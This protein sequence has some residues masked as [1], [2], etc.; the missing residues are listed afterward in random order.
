VAARGQGRAASFKPAEL[1][2]MKLLQT[3][4]AAST[5]PGFHN[6]AATIACSRMTR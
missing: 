3:A 5:G 6:P 2:E 4:Q 1:R